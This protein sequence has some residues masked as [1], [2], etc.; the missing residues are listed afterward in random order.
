MVMTTSPRSSS[1]SAVG[2]GTRSGQCAVGADTHLVPDPERRGA[3]VEAT[4]QA[5]YP[6]VS[7]ESGVSP[8]PLVAVAAGI[9]PAPWDGANTRAWVAVV[10]SRSISKV[11]VTGS[12]N[13]L[14]ATRPEIVSRPNCRAPCRTT[15]MSPVVLSMRCLLKRVAQRLCDRTQ[16]LVTC[17]NCCTVGQRR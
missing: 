14:V 7:Q 5:R 10:T 13:L 4:R 9:K 2:Q 16:F 11:S 15:G 17:P 1:A 3:E 8:K 6:H 12:T